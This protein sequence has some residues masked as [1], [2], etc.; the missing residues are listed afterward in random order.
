[1][2][3]E[4][5]ISLQ[6]DLQFETFSKSISILGARRNELTPY[7]LGFYVKIQDGFDL[8][9]RE[10]SLTVKQWN[11]LRL[12]AIELETGSYDG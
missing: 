12:L 11:H 4:R 9:G 10:L 2:T 6:S 5:R 7:D 3:E 8:A 1:M